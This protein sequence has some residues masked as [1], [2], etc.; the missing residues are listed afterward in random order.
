MWKWDN[1]KHINTGINKRAKAKNSFGYNKWGLSIITKD[2][3]QI[4]ENRGIPFSVVI[5]LKEMEGDNRVKEFVDLCKV[6]DWYVDEL[7]VEKYIDIRNK[8]QEEIEFDK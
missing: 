8:A 7:D 3:V 1:T 4:K 6:N 5:T 2:R